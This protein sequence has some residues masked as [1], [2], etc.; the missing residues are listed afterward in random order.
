MPLQ[1][2]LH[3]PVITVVGVEEIGADEKKDQTC[4][5]EIFVDCLVE[6]N[7]GADLPIMPAV[8]YP[9]VFKH[10]EVGIKSVSQPLIAVRITEKYFQRTAGEVLCLSPC[11]SARP[12][13]RSGRFQPLADPVHHIGS[14]ER[15]AHYWE[16]VLFADGFIFRRQYRAVMTITFMRGAL[17]RNCT[18]SSIPL[19]SGSM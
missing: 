19:P 9:H 15:F 2:T 18:P 10:A 8:N 14:Q 17:W 11:T 7:A 4:G 13:L 16:V 6:V 5:P 1:R 3:L 12:R